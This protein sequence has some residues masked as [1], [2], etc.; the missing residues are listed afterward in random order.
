MTG[1]EETMRYGVVRHQIF[2]TRLPSVLQA[3]LFD[4]V[5][6]DPQFYS[7]ANDRPCTLEIV[8]YQPRQRRHRAIKKRT[9]RI[10]LEAF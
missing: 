9:R 1:Y 10:D 6:F 7:Q 3:P 5:A 2:E 8:S 4:C